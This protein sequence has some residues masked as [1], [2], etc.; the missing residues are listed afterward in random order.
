[1]SWPRA[2]L[3]D[4]FEIS[5]SKRVL[6]K[7]WAESGVPFYRAREIVK[8]AE[9]GIV[10][11]DLFISEELFDEYRNKYGAPEPGDLMV[12]AVGTLGACYVVQPNDRFYYKDAS[13]LRFH[14]SEEVEPR[15][16]Q[17]AFRTRLLLDQVNSGS[18]STV[19]T[20]TIS[21]AKKTKIPLPPLAEQKRIAAILDAAD[22]LRAKRREAIAQLDTLL[23]STFL[24]MFGD[25]VTNPMGWDVVELDSL[26]EDGDKIN[27][28]VVQ[29]GDDYPGGKPLVRVGDFTN[30]VLSDQSLKYIDPEVEKKYSRSRLVGNEILVSCVGSIGNACTVPVAFKGYNI[31]RAVA[32]VPLKK[33]VSREFILNCIRSK[34]VQNYFTKQTRTVSQPTLNISLIKQA[35]IIAP[36]KQQQL[37]FVQLV[38]S[39]RKVQ[40]IGKLHFFELEKLFNSLQQRVFNGTL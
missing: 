8:L 36:P 29:P 24:D 11:N 26:V 31:A 12:S 39:L 14:P 28:G 27:Y 7:Q 17:H 16:I 23:Q 25:P 33:G 21:R 18:G 38:E 30:G 13:V 1:M 34:S 20:F 6:K 4:I 35:P 9:H 5:S 22:K 15:Y 40:G 19:G 32:R 2:T 10:D 37:K 3:G